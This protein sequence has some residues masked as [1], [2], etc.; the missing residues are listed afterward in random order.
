MKTKAFGKINL[1]LWVM[2]KREDDYHEIRTILHPVDIFDEIEVKESQ[3]VKIKC[4]GGPE[5][6]R[7]IV[8]KALEELSKYKKTFLGADIYIR[9]NI[10]IGAGMGGGSSDAAAVLKALNEIYSLDLKREELLEIAGLIGSDVP[11]FIMGKTASGRGRGEILDKL[12]TDFKGNFLI[13]YPGFEI[14]TSWAYSEIN[15]FGLDKKK[16]EEKESIFGKAIDLLNKGRHYEFMDIIENDF[17]RLIFEYY[18][19]FKKI[20]ENLLEKG[21]RKVMLTGS[22]SGLW[23][24]FDEKVEEEIGFGFGKVFWTKSLDW[25][26]V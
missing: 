2:R 1:G 6:D 14:S 4:D 5:G 16:N 8:I 11:F 21:A 23:A 9:K 3:L 22:G 7:N 12:N 25:G 24:Y 26:V 10:P 18:P 20:K 19:F 13:F 17:E 15:K